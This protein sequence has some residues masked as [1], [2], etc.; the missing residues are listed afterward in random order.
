MRFARFGSPV[1][2]PD[3]LEP[4]IRA[5]MVP[6]LIQVP[7]SPPWLQAPSSPPHIVSD[8][9]TLVNVQSRD[10]PVVG[11][12]LIMVMLAHCMAIMC[13]WGGAFSQA[14]DSIA[15]LQSMEG[16][17]KELKGQNQE[18][19]KQK[20]VVEEDLSLKKKKLQYFEADQQDVKDK[21]ESVKMDLEVLH[22]E[23]VGANVAKKIVK[24]GL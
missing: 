23:L 12:D 16:Q 3:S 15:Q 24:E 19:L 5:P 9:S 17:M 1:D 18:L 7:K 10:G 6:F 22:T 11:V 8:P 21:L 13:Q 14:V 2:I 4:F 20:V